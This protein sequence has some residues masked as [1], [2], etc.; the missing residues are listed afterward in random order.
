[1]RHAKRNPITGRYIAKRSTSAE[2]V[3]EH[4]REIRRRRLWEQL[5]WV[6]LRLFWAGVGMAVAVLAILSAERGAL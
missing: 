5:D 2:L 3:E 4:N 1:M 6:T